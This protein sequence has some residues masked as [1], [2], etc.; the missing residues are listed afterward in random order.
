[1]GYYSSFSF[2]IDNAKV[3]VKKA[4]ELEKYFGSND[5]EGVYGFYGMNLGLDGDQLR[6]IVLEEYYAKFYDDELFASKLSEV[7]TQGKVKLYFAGED[8]GQSGY[9]VSPGNVSDIYNYSLT[10]EETKIV[11]KVKEILSGDDVDKKEQLLKILEME[12]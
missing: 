1:M 3:D 12:V 10:E 5:S 9:L 7:L 4:K 8:G 11:D 6:D 2:D